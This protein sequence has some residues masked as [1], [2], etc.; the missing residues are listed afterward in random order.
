MYDKMNQTYKLEI[1]NFKRKNKTVKITLFRIV[2]KQ[3]EK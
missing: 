3:I 1:C 2:G